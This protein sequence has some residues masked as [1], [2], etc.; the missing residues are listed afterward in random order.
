MSI[1]KLIECV[2]YVRENPTNWDVPIQLDGLRNDL[3]NE[4]L[5]DQIAVFTKDEHGRIF[6]LVILKVELLGRSIDGLLDWYA[7]T[8]DLECDKLVA[9]HFYDKQIDVPDN[10]NDEDSIVNAGLWP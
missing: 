1:Q 7:K 6:P 8:H 10:W 9:Y 5:L 4:T 3:H 2:E